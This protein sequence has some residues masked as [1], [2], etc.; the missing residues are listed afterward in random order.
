M[1]LRPYDAYDLGDKK[2]WQYESLERFGKQL[3]EHDFENIK[4][5]IQNISD[6]KELAEARSKAKQEAWMFEGQAGKNIA[7]FMIKTLG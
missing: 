7:D 6:S 1:D 3:D 4:E 5:V 2:L